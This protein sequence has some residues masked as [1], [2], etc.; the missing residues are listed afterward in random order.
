MIAR[1][2]SDDHVHLAAVRALCLHWAS[3]TGDGGL[4]A[5]D[6]YRP[7]RRPDAPTTYGGPA[8]AL[9][10]DGD[11]Y[12]H[13]PLT[14]DATWAVPWMAVY[15]SGSNDTGIGTDE[16][17]TFRDVQV[18]V[19]ARYGLDDDAIAPRLARTV[20]EGCARYLARAAQRVIADKIA[21]TAAALDPDGSDGTFAYGVFTPWSMSSVT[22]E[23]APTA[24]GTAQG[25]A[26]F[27]AIATVTI[28]QS[29]YRSAGTDGT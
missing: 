11:I 20:S 21:V 4:M 22:T 17:S 27:D 9:P 2:V 8:S 3:Y 25:R 16:S 5:T 14:G 12:T 26:V 1:W 15:L 18:T 10:T 7:A 13:S 28:R 19:R 6:P 23:Q 29:Q 24:P